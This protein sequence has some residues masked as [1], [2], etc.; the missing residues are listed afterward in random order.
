VLSFVSADW[1]GSHHKSVLKTDIQVLT[2]RRG[3]MT[4]SRRVAPIPQLKCVGGDAGCRNQPDAVQCRNVGTDGVDIQ[5]EC[6]AD[7]D[8][9]VRFGRL[10]I[11]C[12]GYSDRNDPYVLQGSCGLEY[13]LM[14]TDE[15]KRKQHSG[16]H[17]NSNNYRSRDSDH[18]YDSSESTSFGARIGRIVV[19]SLLILACVGI[20]NACTSSAGING[21]TGNG[22]FGRGFGHRGFFN[23]WNSPPSFGPGCATTGGTSATNAFLGG[24]ALGGLAG[25]AYGRSTQRPSGFTTYASPR[26]YT[27]SPLRSQ[28]SSTTRTATGFASGISTR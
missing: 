24:A 15:G 11:G 22:F 19:V 27:S 14:L 23:G 12:E 21:G 9:T 10:N 13:E 7:L 8:S 26:T 17:Y 3:E 18:Y 28:R 20:W 5:W 1:W 6:K 2:F 4:T 25:Y 16:Y